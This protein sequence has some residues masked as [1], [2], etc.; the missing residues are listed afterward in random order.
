MVHALDT[1]NHQNSLKIFEF[2]K[3]FNRLN[4]TR[5]QNSVEFLEKWLK[6]AFY[7]K[8]TILIENDQ[9]W[10]KL[11][12]TIILIIP[13]TSHRAFDHETVHQSAVK[14]PNFYPENF[15]RAFSMFLILFQWF[16]RLRKFKFRAH[17][18]WV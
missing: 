16:A 9:C 11:I 15:R 12:G 13:E 4:K 1:G 17:F 18:F 7:A 5:V 10:S 6:M 2:S 3:I 14:N 8:I